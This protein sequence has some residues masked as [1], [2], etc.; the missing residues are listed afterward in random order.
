MIVFAGWGTRWTCGQ[1]Q[2]ETDSKGGRQGKGV[3]A[4]REGSPEEKGSKGGKQ[5]EKGRLR[6]RQGKANGG[7]EQAEHRK[8]GPK[9]ERGLRRRRSCL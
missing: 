3:E 1:K 7:E 2:R 4:V 9:K 8:G 6:G 5:G